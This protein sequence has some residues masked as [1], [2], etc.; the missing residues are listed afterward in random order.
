MKGGFLYH[1]MMYSILLGG[2]L[3]GIEFASLLFG[4]YNGWLVTVLSL[5]VY[6]YCMYQFSV[7]YRDEQLNGVISYWRGVQY[8]VTLSFLSSMILGLFDFIWL[9]YIDPDILVNL[10]KEGESSLVTL[11]EQ[12]DD[13]FD[14]KMKEELIEQ[15]RSLTPMKLWKSK[16]SNYVFGGFFVGLIMSFFT[17]RVNS[18]PFHEIN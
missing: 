6:I 7:K 3:V 12:T 17:R 1:V 13:L 8:M 9:K 5:V 4:S 11:F 14:D 16:M 10:I 18:D 2:V 15:A